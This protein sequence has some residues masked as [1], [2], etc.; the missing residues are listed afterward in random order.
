M[1]KVDV[2]SD[3]KMCL[4]AVFDLAGCEVIW[5]DIALA[6]NPRFANNVHNNLSGVSLMRRPL[7]QLR[8]TDLHTLFALHVRARGERVSE[9]ESA[10]LVFSIDRGVTPFDLDRVAAEFM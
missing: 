4:L 1:V 8:K 10:D 2:A 9:V 7:A 5:A 6:G 3:T